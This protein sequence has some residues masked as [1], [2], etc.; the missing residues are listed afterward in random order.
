[1]LVLAVLV[2]AAAAHL[3]RR[4]ALQGRT[5]VAGQLRTDLL[6]VI[7]PDGARPVATRAQHSW[8]GAEAGHS[9]LELSD[10]I[11]AYHERATSARS[12][13]APASVLVLVVIAV[14]HWPAAVLLAAST[15][16]L[17]VNLRVVGLATE[18][19]NRTQ[20]DAVR[21]LSTQLLD[22]FVGMHVIRTLGA[23]DR[24]RRTVRRACDDLNRA[25]IAVLRR[26]FVTT[27]VL[28]VVVTFAIAITAT[29]VGLTLLGYLHL[30]GVPP[31][32]LYSGLFV[33]LLAPAY[34]APM[35]DVAA[36]YHERDAAVAAVAILRPALEAAQHP[37][38]AH[39]GPSTEL[40]RRLLRAPRI[41]LDAVTVRHADSDTAVLD[42]ITV[43][44]MP[45]RFTV[46]SAPSGA[47]KST[48]LAVVGGLREPTAGCVRWRDPV[49]GWAGPP[50]LGRASW[51]GQRTAVIA[52][53]VGENIA[54][55]DP[56]ASQE[57][58]AQVAERAGL[59]PVLAR[60]PD[61]MA[62]V[63]GDGGQGLSAGEARRVALARTLLRDAALWIMD[64][65]TAHLDADTEAEILATLV[66]EGAGRTLLIATH[67]PAVIAQ[68]DVR[69]R[70][71]AGR[72]L[73]A[74]LNGTLR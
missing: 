17:P 41:E 9:V 68:A 67:S 69:W 72:L 51:L 57:M 24:E 58:I 30:P 45:G 47:G 44:V 65:P 21:R 27:A 7:L 39:G 53:S 42:T 13:A 10:A 19:V 8:P 35:K 31:L 28:D 29:Y 38:A 33:L 25:T 32:S 46:L 2:R 18:A 49:T 22:R 73:Q 66:R 64:E 14:V 62:T 20:L 70:L 59:A 43:A 15:P 11:A 61:G 1:V 52:G 36:G 4:Y 50:E 6:S 40:P 12:A 56:G 55:G 26:A 48:L 74:D 60:L 5:A 16:I 23:L 37:E 54:L 71:D 63:I 34:F 3:A